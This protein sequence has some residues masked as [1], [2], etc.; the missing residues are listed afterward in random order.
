MLDPSV[1][2]DAFLVAGLTPDQI[3]QVAAIGKVTTY[4]SGQALVE[5]GGTSEELFVILSGDVRITTHDGDLLGDVGA[6]SVV[7]EVGL[8][9]G[10]PR[11]ANA[12]CNGP[13]SAAVFPIPELRRLMVQNRDWGFTVLANV[14]RLLAGRLRKLNS[15]VDEL[16]DAAEEPWGNALG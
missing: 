7:G 16:S 6:N 5:I 8:V 13:V 9:D 15:R 12:T 2:K 3:A 10:G 4:G 1:L 11:T 14:S